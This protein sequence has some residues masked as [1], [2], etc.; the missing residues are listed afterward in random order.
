[1]QDDLD[2]LVTYLDVL[3]DANR[4]KLLGILR[5][6]KALG[7]I[8]LTPN[9]SQAGDNPDR[10]IS[11]QA[12]RNH[13]D[14]LVDAGLVRVRRAERDDPRV[15]NEY[16]LDTSR[17]FAVV[18]ELD[19]LTQIEARADAGPRETLKLGS[20]GGAE[21]PDGP[22]LVLVHGVREG[23]AFPLD[24]SARDPPRGWIVGRDPE[25]QVCLDYDP[26]V[27]EQNAEVVVEDGT[28]RIMD[29]RASTNRTRVNW[30]PLPVGGERGLEPGDVIG[31]GR[32]RLVFRTS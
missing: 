8:E 30:E 22:K 6:P 31:V 10:T 1:M 18:E 5:E 15:R 16:V 17:L 20:G 25:A 29:L 28:W 27:S 2:A 13:I 24:P 4:L 23:R 21:W 11:R 12:V 19:R 32:S 7:E 14:R 26:F 9:P 3:A